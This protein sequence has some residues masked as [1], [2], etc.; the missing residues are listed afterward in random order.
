MVN[1][2]LFESA[3]A[4]P[5][6]RAEHEPGADIAELA[7]CYAYGIA[8]DHPF[9]DGNKRVAFVVMAVFAQMNGYQLVA[10]E[11]NAVSTMLALA[12]GDLSETDL[13]TWLRGELVPVVR[14]TL[15]V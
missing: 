6:N 9:N 11:V 4:R 10:S 7:A 14:G 12:S 13:A 1:D 5:L 3:L 15:G 8:S 2:G